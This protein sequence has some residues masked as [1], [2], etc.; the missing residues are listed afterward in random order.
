[1][2][3][4]DGRLSDLLLRQGALEKKIAIEKRRIRDHSRVRGAIRA[5]VLGEAL[6]RLHGQGRL[7]EAVV[8][9]LKADLRAHFEPRS[10][11]WEALEDS[12]FDLGSLLRDLVEPGA[13]GSQFGQGVNHKL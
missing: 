11:E 10:T 2:S 4:A 12:A 8:S 9:D 7:A 6:L 3:K 1:M 5:R 13:S